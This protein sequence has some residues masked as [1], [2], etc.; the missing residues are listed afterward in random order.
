MTLRVE[1]ILHMEKSLYQDVLVF[2]STDHGNVLVLDGAI[3]V[4][5][6]SLPCDCILHADVAPLYSVSNVTSSRRFL[7]SNRFSSQ[8]VELTSRILE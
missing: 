1:K 5:F 3:Q 7:R 2:K 4:S 6:L 8:N